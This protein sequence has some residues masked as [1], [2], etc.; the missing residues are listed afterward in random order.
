[1][2]ATLNKKRALKLYR[3][4]NGI[5]LW[6]GVACIA[7]AL[8]FWLSPEQ[9]AKTA[10]GRRLEG[11]IDDAWNLGVMIG[12]L[13]IIYGVWTYRPR[14]EIIGHIFLTASMTIN[15]IAVLTVVRA[16]LSALL[17]IAVAIASAVRIYFLVATTPQKERGT[18]DRS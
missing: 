7:S 9:V 6:I 2:L 10:I 5:W 1:M 15:A 14:S 13:M 12:G 8:Q 4:Q 17:L 3:A 16:G 11:G 18:D